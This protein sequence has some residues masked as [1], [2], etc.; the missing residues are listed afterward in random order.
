MP[1]TSQT[2]TTLALVNGTAGG[3]V[4]VLPIIGLEAGSLMIPVLVIIAAL[5]SF[6]TATIMFDHLGKAKSINQAIKAHFTNDKFNLFYN[7]VMFLSFFGEMILYFDLL[8]EEVDGL[9]YFVG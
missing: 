5:C 3:I 7:L 4:L 9:C 6:Y 2:L 8:V 1:P